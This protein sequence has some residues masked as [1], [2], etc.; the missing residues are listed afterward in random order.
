M[1]IPKVISIN[2][3]PKNS[4][5][6][7]KLS[8]IT[9]DI[10]Q[11]IY[12]STLVGGVI[13]CLLYFILYANGFPSLTDISQL[14][15]LLVITSCIA[16]IINLTV[17]FILIMPSIF[18]ISSTLNPKDINY[19]QEIL[20]IFHII[21]FFTVVYFCLPKNLQLVFIIATLFFSCFT[22]LYHISKNFN[23][24]N[25]SF[26]FIIL[27]EYTFFLL[28]YYYSDST[29]I[30][31]IAFFIVLLVT[32]IKNFQNKINIKSKIFV[33][34]LLY[35]LFIDCLTFVLFHLFLSLKNDD[36]L[37]HVIIFYIIAFS[38]YFV[39]NEYKSLIEKAYNKKNI[40][41]FFI[42]PLLIIFIFSMASNIYNKP[43][44]LIVV[45][46]SS[47]KLGYYPAELQFKDEFVEKTNFFN[48]KDKKI[49]SNTFFILNSIGDEYIIREKSP[50][51]SLDNNISLV[52]INYKNVP[53]WY[54]KDEH[55]ETKIYTFKN[56]H[57]NLVNDINVSKLEEQ[58][59]NDKTSN[60]AN[61]P[62]YR[63]KKE[64]VLYEINSKEL[65][66][67]KTIIY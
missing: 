19:M 50:I 23:N 16:L 20:L 31:L 1:Q 21:I 15:G 32:F 43:N 26:Y 5:N 37:F 24:E 45:P 61:T 7:N 52:A 65:E 67:S 2:N 33:F 4:K 34:F 3:W 13:L 64:D 27:V 48:M 63:I 8:I 66:K 60:D 56:F 29:L 9:R 39:L 53:Y 17:A 58:L 54:G 22:S 41:K 55:N 51:Y 59:N 44:P 25:I 40:L 46:F 12:Y 47:S 18:I 6:D 62:I 36:Y 42:F 30:F 57:L 49:T 10:F 14:L 35:M 28:L 38:N 11:L